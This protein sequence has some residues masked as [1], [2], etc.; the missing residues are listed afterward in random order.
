[1]STSALFDTPSAF[2]PVDST[3][4]FASVELPSI[5][6]PVDSTLALASID[7][8]LVFSPP[9]FATI[10]SPPVFATADPPLAFIT[11][12]SPRRR[13]PSTGSSVSPPSLRPL[14]PWFPQPALFLLR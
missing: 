11:T 1:M 10:A 3:P 5:F 14:F 9:V 12:S 2:E 13:L 4:A 8:P 6:A 7:S